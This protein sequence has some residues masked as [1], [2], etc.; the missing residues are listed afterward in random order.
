MFF[1][2]CLMLLTLCRFQ[3]WFGTFHPAV[4]WLANFL[5]LHT[6][7]VYLND[8]YSS[9]ALYCD[10]PQS[11]VLGPLLFTVYTA[12]LVTLL[13]NHSSGHQF[14]MGDTQF[15]FCLTVYLVIS[16][17]QRVSFVPEKVLSCMV[18]NKYLVDHP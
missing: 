4:N 8:S 1:L 16:P 11:L 18:S 13:D 10:V 5:C 12:P 2:T 14:Y 17:L 9:K 3:L 7:A 15:T 6:Q